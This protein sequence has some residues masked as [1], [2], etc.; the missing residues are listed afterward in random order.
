MDL[1]SLEFFC[2]IAETLSFRQAAEQLCITQPALSV[3]LKRLENE[4]DLVLIQR[5]RQ[6]VKLSQEGKSF[7]PH[8]KRLLREADKTRE[9][10]KSIAQGYVG[11]LRIA[12]TPVSFFGEIPHIISQYR[13]AN[14]KVRITL[15]ELMSNEIEIELDNKRI[16]VGFL[17]PPLSSKNLNYQSLKKE[18]LMIVLPDNHSLATQQKINIAELSEEEF[19][20]VRRDIGPAFYDQIIE[21]CHQQGFTPTINQEAETSVGVVGLVSSGSGIGFVIQSMSSYQ[22]QGVCYREI[23]GKRP[24]LPFALAWRK[25][26]EN[27]LIEQLRETV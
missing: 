17:H 10:A 19:I 18:H 26:E 24:S 23:S 2:A 7:L 8:A 15:V 22:R 14:P 11:E 6:S 25:G 3:R 27:Q 5:T 4:L 16:D 9:V 20:L 21:L 13:E 12:Y 1:R